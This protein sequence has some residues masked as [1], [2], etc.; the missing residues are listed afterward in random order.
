MQDTWIRRVADLITSRAQEAATEWGD[1][2]ARFNELR[3]R[4]GDAELAARAEEQAAEN[5]A[6]FMAG[7]RIRDDEQLEQKFNPHELRECSYC[8][9]LSAKTRK[10]SGCGEARQVAF[11][12]RAP[13][14]NLLTLSISD[15]ATSRARN[16]TGTSTGRCAKVGVDSH[17]SRASRTT[18]QC[19]IQVRY[20]LA[21]HRQDAIVRLYLRQCTENVVRYFACS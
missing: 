13:R 3:R 11:F 7:I 9:L 8:G 2:L 21:W 5:L 19:R 12:N 4:P 16:S 6:N 14:Q 17:S 20:G 18:Y 10:C 1:F 15:I